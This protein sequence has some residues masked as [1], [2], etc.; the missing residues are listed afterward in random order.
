MKPSVK[1]NLKQIPADGPQAETS[2]FWRMLL[3]DV[4]NIT[5]I[6]LALVL[7]PTY[8]WPVPHALLGV[9]GAAGS[10]EA[11]ISPVSNEIIVIN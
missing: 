3:M 10:P 7:S 9:F 1:T 5:L 2:S 4:V 8:P 6:S 11:L